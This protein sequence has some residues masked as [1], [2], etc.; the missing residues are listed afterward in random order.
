MKESPAALLV[1]RCGA[2]HSRFLPR[3]GPCPRC[4]SVEVFPESLSS[5]GVVLASTEL[6]APP[7]GWTAP[8][9]LVLVELAQSVRVL[10]LTDED[11][12]KID[13]K[14]MV[15][16]DGDVYRCGPPPQRS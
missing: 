9:R 3:S 13:A 12:P 15:S 14:V 4:G 6:Q 16:R 2:C 7:T 11:L 5:V 8:H 10:C 1:S